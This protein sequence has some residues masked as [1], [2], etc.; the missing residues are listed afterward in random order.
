M[1]KHIITITL[2]LILISLASAGIELNIDNTDWSSYS[3]ESNSY[4]IE[5]CN[6]L[7]EREIF[8]S[9]DISGNSY[10]MSGINF[11]FSENPIIFEGCKDINF[12]ITSQANYQP[13]N[14]SISIYAMTSQSETIGY[15]TDN[16][17]ITYNDLDVELI[18]E[19]DTN[20]TVEVIKTSANPKSGFSIPA[21]GIFLDIK[22]DDI[23]NSTTIK[24]FYTDQEVSDAGIVEST[25][26]LY[27]FNETSQAWEKYDGLE[28]GVDTTNNY[29]WA[30][31]NHFS[32]WGAFGT[33]VVVPST[34]SGGWSRTK[35]LYADNIT[36][37]KEVFVDRNI[38]AE[39]KVCNT[40]D[41]KETIKETIDE[42][43]PWTK[44]YW[45][46]GII[47]LLFVIFKLISWFRS[48]SA[49]TIE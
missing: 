30:K 41:I 22:S 1:R 23:Q 49:T 21:L 47:A 31:T 29:V 7:G 46:L 4:N 12:V 43:S 45:A 20:G 48:D 35:Y 19:S 25:M 16:N 9:Y 36:I 17:S 13:D 10:D 33:A 11:S 18:I 26:R 44:V 40:C 27:Y 34:S 28:G 39:P 3:G 15:T 6:E 24:V 42:S 14:Y 38:T 32:I 8:L 5:V 37:V 2:G